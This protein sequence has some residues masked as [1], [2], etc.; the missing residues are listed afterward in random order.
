MSAHVEERL[1]LPAVLDKCEVLFPQGQRQQQQQQQTK[2]AMQQQQQA[3]GSGAAA[4][5]EEEEEEEE[6]LQRFTCGIFYDAEALTL[7]PLTAA[8][9]AACTGG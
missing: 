2:A 1:P 6:G 5:E 9:V 8:E 3:G 4:V 7:R